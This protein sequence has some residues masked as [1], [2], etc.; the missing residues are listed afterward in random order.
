MIARDAG[1]YQVTHS[2]VTSGGSDLA[3]VNLWRSYRSENDY[4]T[5]E[6]KLYASRI[7]GNSDIIK[8]QWRATMF[9]GS[10]FW[11]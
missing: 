1:D 3:E 2:E 8:I 6:G 10:E 11:D 5:G 7:N 9:Y 4:T